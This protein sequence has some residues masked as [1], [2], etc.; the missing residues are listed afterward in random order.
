MQIEEI[1]IDGKKYL[2]C[3]SLR[4]ETG[5][6]FSLVSSV[7]EKGYQFKSQQEKAMATFYVL[8]SGGC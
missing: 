8:F 1:Y 6:E 7:L 5:K 3:K 4:Q 2:M